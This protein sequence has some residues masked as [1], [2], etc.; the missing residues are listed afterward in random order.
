MRRVTRYYQWCLYMMMS[1]L[2]T[3]RPGHVSFYRADQSS[4][5]HPWR[6][7]VLLLLLPAE[8]LTI[9]PLRSPPLPSELINRVLKLFPGYSSI[10]KTSTMRTTSCGFCRRRRAQEWSS[11]YKSDAR[12]WTTSR[13]IRVI[14]LLLGMKTDI[15]LVSCVPNSFTRCLFKARRHEP[16]PKYFSLSHAYLFLAIDLALAPQPCFRML[17]AVRIVSQNHTGTEDFPHYPT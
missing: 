15:S 1:A 14:Q 3:A 2:H 10:L 16:T 13:Q 12:S 5:Q 8:V 7:H 17:P 9:V 11:E 4:S 6:L